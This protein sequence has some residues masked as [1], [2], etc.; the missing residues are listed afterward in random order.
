MP[1]NQRQV[2]GAHR[3]ARRAQHLKPRHARDQGSSN[4]RRPE[5]QVACGEFVVPALDHLARTPAPSPFLD[6][7]G[8]A[9]AHS[10]DAVADTHVVT[11]GRHSVTAKRMKN[12]A[13][14]RQWAAEQIRAATAE[15]RPRAGEKTL[16]RFAILRN[17]WPEVVG[18]LPLAGFTLGEAVYARSY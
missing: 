7:I 17:Y 6:E 10:R 2:H 1:V 9:G 5:R 11:V 15:V 18:I 16:G 14:A 8:E 3:G 12:E 13:P 4:A